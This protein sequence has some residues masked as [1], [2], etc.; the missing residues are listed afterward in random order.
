MSQNESDD[1]VGS[2]VVNSEIKLISLVTRVSFFFLPI[3][4]RSDNVR[5]QVGYE[6]TSWLLI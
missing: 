6:P 1:P 5:T 3:W 2:G 4:E